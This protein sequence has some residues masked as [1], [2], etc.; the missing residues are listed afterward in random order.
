MEHDMTTP[1]AILTTREVADKVGT[2]PKTLCACF[3]VHPT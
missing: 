1:A 3:C 2:D